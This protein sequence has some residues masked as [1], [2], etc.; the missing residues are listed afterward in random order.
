MF[1]FIVLIVAM[2]GLAAAQ[3]PGWAQKPVI[4][5]MMGVEQLTGSDAGVIDPGTSPA[6]YGVGWDGYVDPSNISPPI[7]IPLKGNVYITCDF[8][9]PQYTSH[10]GVDVV[11]WPEATLGAPVYTTMVGKVIY[12]GFNGPW[13]NLVVI[14]N[15]GY[16]VWFAHLSEIWVFEGEIAA[17]GAI[18]GLV[19]STGNSTGPHLH[20]GIKK[21]TEGGQVWLDPLDFFGGEAYGW[22]VC[23]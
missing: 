4:A 7:G 8:H 21:Q 5:W 17:S 10:S 12:A 1:G 2:I 13:G 23:E 19:G 22:A 16:Q 14:E 15:N 18:V 9:D 3:L 6:G 11:L 20:Y